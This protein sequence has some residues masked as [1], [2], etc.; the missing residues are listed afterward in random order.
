MDK[1]IAEVERIIGRKVE[2]KEPSEDMK[3]II[4]QVEKN[5]IKI[6]KQLEKEGK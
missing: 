5:Q 1:I 6:Q 2:L 4:Q 3:E